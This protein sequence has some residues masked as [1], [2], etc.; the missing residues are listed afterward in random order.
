MSWRDMIPGCFGL[1]DKIFAGHQ[2]EKDAVARL[3]NA[4]KAAGAT[5]DD[6][7][8]ALYDWVKTHVPVD[9]QDDAMSAIRGALVF[10]R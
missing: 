1:L 7:F 6:L 3:W 10:Y 2:N 9:K 8:A 4:A 5:E